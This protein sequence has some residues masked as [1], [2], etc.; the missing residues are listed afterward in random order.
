V[1]IHPNDTVL[2]DAFGT[3][4]LPKDLRRALLDHLQA[5]SRCR[6]RLR[7]LQR[8]PGLLV[9]RVADRLL[10]PSLA[11]RARVPDCDLRKIERRQAALTRE[12]EEAPILLSSLLSQPPEQ[13]RLSISNQKRYQTW[14]LTELLL[15]RSA[16]E[17]LRGS[18]PAEEMARLALCATGHLTP[19][20]YGGERIEDL[21]ARSWARIGNALRTRSDLEGAESAFSTAFAHLWKGTG[22]LHEKAMCLD[23]KASL[24]RAQR[25]LQS[26]KRLQERAIAIFLEIGETHS[27][28]RALFNLHYIFMIAGDPQEG[29]PVLFRAMSLIDQRRE[30]HL[31][32]FASHNLAA[33]LCR[34]GGFAEAQD[35]LNKIRP[36]YEK[37]AL[38]SADCRRQ[39]LEG[40]IALQL[41]RHGEARALLMN[42]RNGFLADERRQEASLVTEDLRSCPLHGLH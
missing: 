24:L 16:E 15:D 11:R 37:F 27:A 28:G 21:R 25:R 23:L 42:A 5:C 40:T 36:L 20:R 3:A 7:R 8:P 12:R 22:D 33:N 34:A 41:G 29:V 10:E 4:D 9:R 6:E 13:R 18:R 30:P 17:V 31:M 1:R 2:R 32:F 35:L 39:W 19:E 14:G 26:A 38:R